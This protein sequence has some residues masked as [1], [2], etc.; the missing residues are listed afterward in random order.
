[1]NLICRR[2]W[3]WERLI[4][5]ELLIRDITSILPI[6]VSYPNIWVSI[7]GM[8]VPLIKF[9]DTI[10]A[11]HFKNHYYRQNYCVWLWGKFR[12]L[13]AFLTGQ[14]HCILYHFILNLCILISG[15]F[16]LIVHVSV[17]IYTLYFQYPC[18]LNHCVYTLGTFLLISSVSNKTIHSIS[19]QLYH[20]EALCFKF[21]ERFCSS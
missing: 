4:F 10:H 19:L 6:L 7:S 8:I 18:M 17:E 5:L 16:L 15:T 9:S 21:R 20:A 14:T 1:M 11:L 3:I 2:V 13:S 12:S